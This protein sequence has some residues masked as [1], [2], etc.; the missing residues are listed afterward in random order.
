[1]TLAVPR[2]K[3]FLPTN[4]PTYTLSTGA[5]EATWPE[6]YPAD[7]HD[8]RP[9][10]CQIAPITGAVCPASVRGLGG[11]AQLMLMYSPP[12][13]GVDRTVPG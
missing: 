7:A 2:A 10:S 9:P 1:M 5:K 11:S 13:L 8:A 6:Q 3:G 4:T 12:A